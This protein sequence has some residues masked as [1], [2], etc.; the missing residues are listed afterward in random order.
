MMV[1]AFRIIVQFALA[2]GYIFEL[3]SGEKGFFFE[4]HGRI[5][6][7]FGADAIGAGA[8]I[9]VSPAAGYEDQVFADVCQVNSGT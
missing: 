5:N 1:I 9:F 3:A 2:D 8:D 4:R 6:A 7:E